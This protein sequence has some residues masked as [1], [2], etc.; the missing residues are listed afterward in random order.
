[1]TA[2]TTKMPR[3][4]YRMPPR[5]CPYLKGR[6]EQNIF[7]ELTG[8]STIELYDTLTQ[9]GFRRSHNVAYRPACPDCQACV[10]IRVIAGAFEPGSSIRRISR[11]NLDLVEQD[12]PSRATAEQY[13]LFIRYVSSR[14][15]DGEMAGMGFG[16]Y[17]AMVQ[18]SPLR[19]FI[20]EFRDLD[21]RLR[22]CALIDRLEDGLSAVYSYFDPAMD[23]RSL[24]TYMII[25]M[26]AKSLQLSLPYLYLGYWIEGSKK[27]SYKWRFRPLEGLTKEGWKPV[28][29]RPLEETGRIAA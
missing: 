4:F 10:P 6:T 13:E 1:M 27:M 21:G 19:T 29:L 17:A 24:G 9:A 7:T 16:D 26:I 3:F 25:R 28:D 20:T 12:L 22:A 23:Q 5:P 18:D 11:R 15:G 2:Q 8:R 14:H